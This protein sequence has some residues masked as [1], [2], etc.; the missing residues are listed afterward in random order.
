[1]SVCLRELEIHHLV[2]MRVITLRSNLRCEYERKIIVIPKITP[3]IMANNLLI[4][5]YVINN[6]LSFRKHEI[7]QP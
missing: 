5:I 3:R 6:Y 1:M 7:S 2:R 4:R